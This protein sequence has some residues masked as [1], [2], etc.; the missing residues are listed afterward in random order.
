ME[1]VKNSNRLFGVVVTASI[2]YYLSY[3]SFGVRTP[4]E[5]FSTT[6][7]QILC[8]LTCLLLSSA[9]CVDGL[10]VSPNFRPVTHIFLLLANIYLVILPALLSVGAR[11]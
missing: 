6:L 2:L 9:L 8:A 11:H 7:L 1:S 5:Y 4:W 3:I 10:S